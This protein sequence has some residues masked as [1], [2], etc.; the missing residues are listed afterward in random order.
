MIDQKGD[1]QPTPNCS[2]YTRTQFTDR[3]GSPRVGVSLATATQ[4]RGAQVR[5]AV[6][7]LA[8]GLRGGNI[9]AVFTEMF[10]SST[11]DQMVGARP[12]LVP[13]RAAWNLVSIWL[14]ARI[15]GVCSA[16]RGFHEAEAW[17]NGNSRDV[18]PRL[19]SHVSAENLCQ[20]EQIL[21]CLI[22]DAEF[23]HL[24]PYILEEH[25]PGSR[26][27]AMKDPSTAAA[28]AA[29]RENGVFYTPSDVA[30]YMVEHVR[31]LYKGD[32]LTAKVLDPACGTGVF[33]L[34]LLRTAARQHGERFSP[35]NYITSCL[36]G[37]DLSGHALDAAA[38]LLL[39]ECLTEVRTLG[40]RPRVAW[41]SIRRNLV[42]IDSVSLD[43]LPHAD[44]RSSLHLF[45]NPLLGLKE[46]FPEAPDGF[47]ILVGN[48]PYV[49]L[50]AR[51]DYR[52]LA[53]R[54]VSLSGARAS[55]KVN[56]FPLFVEMMWQFT[57][58]GCNAAALVTP[59]SIAFHIGVQY[60]NCRHTMSWNGGRWQ[61]AFFD[62]EPH[63]LFGEEVKTRNAILFRTESA[64]TPKRGQAA[65]IETGPL[66]KWTS[67][68]RACLFQRI[69]FT[70]LG[71]V[72]IT[73]GIPKLCGTLQAE[74]FMALRRTHHRFPTL[75]LQLGTCAP[76]E[77]VTG[78]HAPKVFVGGTAYNF[79]NVYRPT[80]LQPD[81]SQ[82]LLSE[83]PVHCLHFKTEADAKAAFAILS[84]R[85]VF[86]LW[87]VLGDGFHVTSWLF[88]VIPFS[89]E[90]FLQE[91][92]DSLS[93]F[94]KI[95]WEKLQSHRFISM[96]RGRLTIGFRPLACHEER[97]G[98]DA[99]LVKAAGLNE[100]V[101][102]ELRQ[103]VHENAVVDSTDKRRNHIKLHFNERSI[104]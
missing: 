54:F 103:F 77:A 82:C 76:V 20:A 71:S 11:Y 32:F 24:L 7:V 97:N 50:G 34:A 1:N 39:K 27:S 15:D 65:N 59:L 95:L 101:A 12:D 93:Q 42:E 58:P 51:A 96:N 56:L 18:E 3:Y 53:N 6:E 78:D 10:A 62:R 23:K 4:L 45:N 46:L 37:F 81:E 41:Q 55:P 87:H 38:F 88:K 84:S 48:P 26:A 70:A 86:W 31:Q 91:E 8:T 52:L 14:A 66:R 85:L 40:I 67:R 36:H 21:D 61:F 64:E 90:S 98:I 57:K 16:N 100:Q 35:F 5:E 9:H 43:T 29:K 68:T 79:L 44:T 47:D 83:S 75:A 80:N 60:K 69:D 22:V 99:I 33:L 28:R 94:G 74:M 25:G 49:E 17:F 104:D 30:D 63:A 72:D 19:S 89:K 13:I 73:T 102:L 92:F 2:L